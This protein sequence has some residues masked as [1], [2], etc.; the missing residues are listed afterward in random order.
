MM[1]DVLLVA[2][3]E[4]NDDSGDRWIVI[5]AILTAKKEASIRGTT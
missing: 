2:I 5:L 1:F 4:A 3:A